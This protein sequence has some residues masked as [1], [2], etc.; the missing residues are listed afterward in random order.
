MRLLGRKRIYLPDSEDNFWWI[1]SKA[2]DHTK[3]SK[4][5][6]Q[7]QAIKER[8]PIIDQIHAMKKTQLKDNYTTCKSLKKKKLIAEI[9]EQPRLGRITERKCLRAVNCICRVFIFTKNKL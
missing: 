1:E 8:L 3:P 9:R 7:I 6:S 4:T 5:G 2:T